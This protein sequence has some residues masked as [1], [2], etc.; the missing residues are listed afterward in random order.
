LEA[1]SPEMSSTY[2]Q[3]TQSLVVDN[4]G[5]K[6][7][8][9]QDKDSDDG[10]GKNSFGSTRQSL[11]TKNSF[12]SDQ[13]FEYCNV[14][15]DDDNSTFSLK[16]TSVLGNLD[17]STNQGDDFDQLSGDPIFQRL[18]PREQYKNQNECTCCSAKFSALKLKKRRH[19]KFCGNAIC[20]DHG[21][22]KRPDPQNTTATYRIC[23]KCDTKYLLRIILGDYHERTK[24]KDREIAEYEKKMRD[25]QIKS[26]DA[27]REYESLKL[28]KNKH[29]KGYSDEMFFITGE[30]NRSRDDTKKCEK[31]KCHLKQRIQ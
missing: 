6:A 8:S 16:G 31:R 2:M 21:K 30:I 9:Y 25:Y 27:S 13:S 18:Y 23:D 10:R 12:T 3:R 22:K 29:E 4:Y 17:E 28:K 5:N 11:N 20:D 7:M 1:S 15:V 19:C 24:R 14:D 26:A